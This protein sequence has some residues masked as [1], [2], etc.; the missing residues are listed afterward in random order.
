M[1]GPWNFQYSE[2]YFK[3]IYLITKICVKLLLVRVDLKNLNFLMGC[4]YI[5]TLLW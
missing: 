1:G 5:P 2:I 4:C 3:T